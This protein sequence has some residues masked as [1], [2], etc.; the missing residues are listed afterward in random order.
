MTF[1][2]DTDNDDTN[3]YFAWYT[4]GSDGSGTE[5]LKIL[6]TGDASFA[7]TVEIPGYIT[8]T[9]DPDT[10]IGFNVDDTIEL[11]CGGNLQI[12][13]DAS[14]AYLRY[15]GDA[16]LYTDNTGIN[17]FGHAYPNADSTY[18]LGNQI[19]IGLTLT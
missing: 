4:N 16:K 5:L 9:G 11:R 14:R 15:Q 1:N 6:E 18:D 8:H 3:R 13:A 10:K 19:Y 12:N 7:G 2:I 17:F